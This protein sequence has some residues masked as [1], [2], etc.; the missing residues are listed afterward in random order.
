ML[1]SFG[2]AKKDRGDAHPSPSHKEDVMVSC[3]TNLFPAGSMAILVN[4][5]DPGNNII[6][7]G[8]VVEVIEV[9]GEMRVVS[10]MGDAHIICDVGDL[11]DP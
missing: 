5:D 8:T 1:R 6:V 7:S 9:R 10:T 2:G 4:E 3:K 11:L